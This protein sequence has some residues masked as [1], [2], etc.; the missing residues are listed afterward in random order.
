MNLRAKITLVMS[1]LATLLVVV[2]VAI[3]LYAFRTFSVASA[4]EHLRSAAEVVRVALTEAMI[5]GVI[6]K[7]KNLLRRL[8]EVDGLKSAR[9]VRSPLVEKQFGKGL[10][11]EAPAD[12]FERAVLSEGK[13]FYQT[14][15][16]AGEEIFRGTIPFTATSHGT[17]NC[18]Q[19]HQ[20]TEGA[21]LGAVTIEISIEDLKRKALTTVASIVG[22]IAAIS[23]LMVL[24]LRRLVRPVAD[25]AAAV[26]QA[27]Q[28]ALAG[29]FKASIEQRTHDEIGQIATDMNRLLGF[30]DRGLSRIGSDVAT[31]TKRAPLPGEN[32]LTASIDAVE[33]LTKAAHFKQ[34]I[35]EDESK[36]EIYQRLSR[37]LKDEYAIEEFSIYETVPSKNQIIPVIVDGE[38]TENCRW[39][40]P[41]ILVRAES[42][43]AGRTG[44]LVDG[45]TTPKICY[46]FQPPVGVEARTHICVPLIQSGGVGC[47]V[48][49]VVKPENEA[50]VHDRLPFINVYLREAGPVIEAKRLMQTLRDANL[51]DAM[52]GLNNRRF[53]EEF[54]DTLVANV[55]RRKAQLAILMLDLDYFKMVNDTYGHDAGDA[56]LKALAK[57]LKQCVRASD[58][59]IRYG[60]EEFLIILLDS[61]QATGAEVAEKIR[62]AVEALKIAVGGT[63]L[64]KTISIGVSEYPKDS[65][66]FWQAVKFADVALYRAKETGRN[67]VTRFPRDLGTTET[68]DY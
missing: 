23:L 29:N 64:Q 40:D 48:Q 50:R 4:T 41:Q 16:V 62:E 54:V 13:P 18:L 30:L 65:E 2:L 19:C 37:V 39:C 63:T 60:G 25:T 59:V 46:A 38:Q 20:V 58:M 52:T 56:V 31:L 7:G 8:K 35:E 3:S 10:A 47:V 24:L 43:R 17:P 11:S 9:V 42:C 1:T 55:Q 14:T 33:I 36:A 27:V 53:L 49:L 57:V 22:V 15:T 66:T 12:D 34:A 21:V 28:Q 6:D 67:R 61:D 45:V 44:H 5:N 51:R 68:K 32:Q 26:E